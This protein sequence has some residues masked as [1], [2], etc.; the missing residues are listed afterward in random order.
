MYV[1]SMRARTGSPKGSRPTLPTVQRPKL[2][3]SAGVGSKGSLAFF[4][5]PFFT[6]GLRR[7]FWQTDDSLWS[8]EARLRLPAVLLAGLGL[9]ACRAFPVGA[10][11]PDTVL[12]ALAESSFEER[13]VEDEL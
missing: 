2:K 8:L 6:A 4:L 12:D 3:R 13:L 1:G 10:Y 7:G 11:V 5:L 9:V